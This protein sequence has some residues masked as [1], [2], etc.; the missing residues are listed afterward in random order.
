MLA[1]VTDQLVALVEDILGVVEFR[2]DRVLHVVEEFQH[3]TAWDDAAGGHGDATRLL[4]DRTQF[5]QSFEY[6]IHSYLCF[7]LGGVPLLE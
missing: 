5:V 3:I 7:P 6:S 2:G 1:G 4:D